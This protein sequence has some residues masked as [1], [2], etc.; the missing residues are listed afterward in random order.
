MV[1]AEGLR[2]LPVLLAAGQRSSRTAL[3]GIDPEARLRRPLD[4]DLRPIPIPREGIVL[5]ARLAE[6]LGIGIGDQVEAELLTGT[7]A[8]LSLRVAGLAD[9]LI[10][11]SAY[12]HP[13][14]LARAAGDGG[15]VDAVAVRLDPNATEA[16]H[17]SILAAPRVASL[18]IKAMTLDNFRRSTGAVVLLVAGIFALFAI[19]IAFGV[20]YNNLR[21]A[22][23]ERARE[24]ATLRILGLTRREV[25]GVLFAE[26]GVMLAVGIPVG[27]VL[28]TWWVRWLILAF[29]TEMFRIPATISPGSYVS[30][31]LVVAGA[32][33]VSVVTVERRL[34]RLDLVAVLK[35]RD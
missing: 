34:A 27:L 33:L 12:M 4:A 15:R 30:A 1:A 8:R 14:A 22:F 13:A 7:R 21:I 20:V 11:L 24:L 6:R 23:Q 28:G 31:G 19:S 10:G 16:F 25:G 2:S 32:A 26:I 5:S 35:A 9:D 18:G 3:V 17:R 29:E